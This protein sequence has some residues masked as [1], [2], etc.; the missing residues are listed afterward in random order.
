MGE[1]KG[2]EILGYDAGKKVHTYN[3]FDSMGMRGSG[4]LKVSGDTWTVTG[5]SDMGGTTFHDRCTLAF[6]A[7]S[8]TLGIKCEMSQDGKSWAPV[9]E[10]KATKAK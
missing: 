4:T 5:T 6:G 1:M 3:F 10:G 9:F 7:G 8:T 2:V